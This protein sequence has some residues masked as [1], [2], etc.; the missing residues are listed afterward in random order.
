MKLTKLQFVNYV[1]TYE[2]M[3]KESNKVASSLGIVEWVPDQWVSNYYEML[4]DMCELYEDSIVGTILDWFC[5]ETDFGANT[6][7]NKIYEEGHEWPWRI[8]SAEILYDYI[9]RED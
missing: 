4:S 3:L 8:E 2:E 9:M 1:N 6:E 5:F 7:M